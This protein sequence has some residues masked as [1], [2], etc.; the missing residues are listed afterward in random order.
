ML[1]SI[2]FQKITEAM[3]KARSEMP[4][5]T[6]DTDNTYFKSRYASLGAIMTT[7]QPVLDKYELSIIHTL[8][9]DGTNV[10]VTTRV[11]HYTSGE[12]IESHVM[13]PLKITD[14][15]Q[16]VQ[17]AGI[18][19]T[20][21]RRYNINGMFNLISEDD[22]DGNMGYERP[23]RQVE[24]KTS[25]KSGSTKSTK[26]AKS[27]KAHREEPTGS[28]KNELLAEFEYKFEKAMKLGNAVEDLPKINEVPSEPELIEA[29]A[30]LNIIL[31]ESEE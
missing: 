26:P 16:I 31:K 15:G 1:T 29:L 25:F 19:F 24:R 12:W 20:Y 28:D 30:E 23:P 14:K 5:I 9:G 17:V 6:M 18:D 27:A 21:L 11:S 3:A 2:N 8:E 7:I 10:G 13:V 4:T 22:T